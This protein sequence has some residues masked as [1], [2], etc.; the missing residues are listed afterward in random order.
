MPAKKKPATSKRF[1]VE[2][3]DAEKRYWRTYDTWAKGSSVADVRRNTMNRLP[4][5]SADEI[6][7]S[8]IAARKSPKRSAA[9]NPAFA[10]GDRVKVGSRRGIVW[11]VRADGHVA[12]QFTPRGG[13][14]YYAP[15]T[16]TH[17]RG[18]A[19]AKASHRVTMA[20]VKSANARYHREKG[21]AF[22][23]FDRK[24]QRHFGRDKFSGPYSGPGGT[25]FVTSTKVG[26]AVYRVQ[27]SGDIR[28]AAHDFRSIDAARDAAKGL[29]KGA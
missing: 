26:I 22:S 14:S 6:R 20:D 17:V 10:S 7:V 3:W 9:R 18:G 2:V 23:F 11:N 12:V 5:L 21:D 15:S 4:D 29:A 1:V 16:V 28:F 25:F 13:A 24:T 8:A 27:P 19:G